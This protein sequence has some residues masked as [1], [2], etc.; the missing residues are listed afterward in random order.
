MKSITFNQGLLAV[1]VIGL[2][3]VL[4]EGWAA[5]GALRIGFGESSEGEMWL[6][7]T[8]ILQAVALAIPVGTISYA[9]TL[10]DRGPHHPLTNKQFL[11]LVGILGLIL[12]SAKA[13][14]TPSL[15]QGLG[16]Q[17]W[18]A[19]VFA[20][21]VAAF[22]IA[23]T[24]FVKSGRI[25]PETGPDGPD[26]PLILPRLVEGFALLGL[27]F[28]AA[29]APAAF[30]N[31][32]FLDSQGYLVLHVVASPLTSLI[33]GGFM[34][35]GALALA[36]S[37]IRASIRTPCS[38][39]LLGM[40][41]LFALGAAIV[42]GN[43]GS[44]VSADTALLSVA[45]L[46]VA[47]LFL[48]NAVATDPVGSAAPPPQ[49]GRLL[50]AIGLAG[51]VLA[52]AS[53]LGVAETAFSL[54]REPNSWNAELGIP[55]FTM[56]GVAAV[57][58]LVILLLGVRRPRGASGAGEP[59]IPRPP[60]GSV[61]LVSSGHVWPGVGLLGLTLVVAAG[62]GI[63][64]LIWTILEAS[65]P[66]PSVV[67]PIL[68]LVVAVA[69][70]LVLTQTNVRVPGAPPGGYAEPDPANPLTYSGLLTAT[71]LLGLV[72]VTLTAS[73]NALGISVLV[74][75]GTTSPTWI[76]LTQGVAFLVPLAVIVVAFL[77]AR[78]A[79][80]SGVEAD[81]H[82]D[83]PRL[84]L[85]LALLGVAVA[86]AGSPSVVE[87]LRTDSLLSE[88]ASDV[89]ILIHFAAGCAALLAA[90]SLLLGGAAKAWAL[91]GSAPSPVV[92]GLLALGVIVVVFSFGGSVIFPIGLVALAVVALHLFKSGEDATPGTVAVTTIWRRATVPLLGLAILMPLTPPLAGL[93]SYDPTAGLSLFI[94]LTLAFAYTIN[95][96]PLARSIAE[97]RR[98]A[99]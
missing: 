4:A 77:R 13:P 10:W 17:P 3:L 70:P 24:A 37:R 97:L 64:T 82:I 1:G 96:W 42:A 91:L 53:M 11:Q 92:A 22:A 51:M 33:V 38:A 8:L 23:I 67:A 41:A 46:A 90:F 59:A 72:V 75:E 66:T 61:R 79:A 84:A 48:A 58:N 15:M 55:G 9:L 54:G 73:A 88:L 63:V 44:T 40:T 45:I 98:E 25:R 71:G 94:I 62:L 28:A 43:P 2:T 20:A 78:W 65:E 74:W 31:I 5:V 47:G 86:A 39:A 7:F 83:L 87:S 29:A 68:L 95:L 26:D 60:V 14:L 16:A 56:T 76:T 36:S 12:V 93:V 57:T 81:D 30:T 6:P 49:Q 80:R 27:A 19:G 89:G 85:C 34:A 50:V 18:T 52:A 35:I 32:A 21:Q 69:L 99:A